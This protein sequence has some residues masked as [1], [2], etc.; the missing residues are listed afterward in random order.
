MA[1]FC[2]RH[3]MILI[4]DEI[5]SDL[6]LPGH[7]HLPAALAAPEHLDRMVILLAA[8][9]TFDIAGLRTGCLFAPG[10]A[11]RN[12]ITTLHRSL[13]IQP[14]RFGVE[15]STAAWSDEGAA[16]LADLMVYLDGNRAVFEEGIAAIPGVTTMPMQATFLAWVNFSGTGMEEDEIE[17]RIREEA[18]ILPSPGPAF[19]T[20]GA[21]H[22]RFNLGTSRARVR[23]AVARLQAAFADLQ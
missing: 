7:K 23:E 4:S 19:G 12:R 14:N 3:D 16:W 20:G 22:A 5:H 18:R 1:E 6:I 9:K 8:S 11:V 21:Q 17:R 13:D 2:A 15:L 10:E